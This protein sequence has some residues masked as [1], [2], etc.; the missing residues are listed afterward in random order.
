MTRERLETTTA[1]TIPEANG[2]IIAAAGEYRAVG[3][4][5][6]GSHPVRVALQNTQAMTGMTIPQPHRVVI[7]AACEHTSMR[8]PRQGP[9]PIGMTF[10]GKLEHTTKSVIN[11]N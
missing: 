4:E 9:H 5:R 2:R 7:T 3:A 1:S 10:K 6:D 11:L 8:T